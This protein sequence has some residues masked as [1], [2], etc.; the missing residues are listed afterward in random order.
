MKFEGGKSMPDKNF[1]LSD[2][3]IEFFFDIMIL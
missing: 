1:N 3:E 2:L